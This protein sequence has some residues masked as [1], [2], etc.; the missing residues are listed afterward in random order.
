MS[1]RDVDHLEPTAENYQASHD[2]ESDDPFWYTIVETVATA[3]GTDASEVQP[4]YDV[5]DPEALT[6]VFEPSP[7][8][9]PTVVG[10]LSF[11]LHD[12]VVTITSDGSVVAR[13]VCD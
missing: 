5:V 10:R 12:C 9:E 4:L 7:D 13:L 1:T 8:G 6:Q 11:T 2:W 3:T